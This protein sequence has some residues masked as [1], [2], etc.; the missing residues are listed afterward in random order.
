MAETAAGAGFAAE[1]FKVGRVGGQGRL[2]HLERDG[3]VGAQM[4]GPEHGSH[5]AAAQRLID[6][7]LAV[8]DLT[9]WIEFRG[10][11]HPG[12]ETSTVLSCRAT[13]QTLRAGKP[14]EAGV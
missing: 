10:R 14:G 3:A 5:A 11:R 2:E 6:A 8:D 9:D 12:R 1:A 13:P 7:V 4:C